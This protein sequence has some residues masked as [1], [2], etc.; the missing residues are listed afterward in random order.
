MAT[1]PK[2][3]KL[4]KYTINDDIDMVESLLDSGAN[5]DDVDSRG[6]TALHWAFIKKHFHI[7]NLLITYGANEKIRDDIEVI[8]RLYAYVDNPCVFGV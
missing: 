8:P 6:K 2:F 7:A 5:V 4:I 3:P 1:Y